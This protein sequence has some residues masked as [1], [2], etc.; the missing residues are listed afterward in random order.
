MKAGEMFVRRQG[1]E[2]VT[3]AADLTELKG[4]LKEFVGEMMELGLW[5]PGGCLHLTAF[6]ARK[7]AHNGKYRAIFQ[8]G[9]AMFRRLPKTPE[10]DDC[11]L[12]S[13]MFGRRPAMQVAGVLI[14]DPNEFVYDLESQLAKMAAGVMPEVHC[15]L[16]LPDCGIVLDPAAVLLPEHCANVMGLDWKMPRPKAMLTIEEIDKSDAAFYTPDVAAMV[17]LPLFFSGYAGSVEHAAASAA[18]HAD[19]VAAI[20]GVSQWLKANVGWPER[21]RLE[22]LAEGGPAWKFVRDLRA[23]D[24]AAALAADREAESLE[25][26]GAK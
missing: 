2:S 18:F 22:H 26:N 12:F 14:D 3:Q 23:A 24:Q 7:I 6:L 13:F 25:R 11:E 10:G 17:A 4:I 16:A 15:W 21:A 5:Q 1:M 9:T 20:V 19:T 8:A